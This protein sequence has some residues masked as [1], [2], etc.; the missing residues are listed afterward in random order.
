VVVD[1]IAVGVPESTPVE[2]SRVTPAGSVGDTVHESTAPPL[3]EGVTAVIAVP[4]VKV[5][6]V[7]L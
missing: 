1:T 3:A 5:N 2:E 4:F 7:P 6:G